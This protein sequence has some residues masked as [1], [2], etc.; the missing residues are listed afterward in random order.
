MIVERELRFTREAPLLAWRLFRVRRLADGYALCAPM[1]HSPSPPPWHPGLTV[2]RCLEHDHAAPAPGCR[3]GIYAAIEG[4]LDSLPGYLLDTAYDDDPWTYAEVACSGRVFLDARGVRCE[5]ALV[6]QIALVEESFASVDARVRAS[7][8]LA[9]RYG[10]CVGSS[11]AAPGWLADNSRGQGD[12]FETESV[13]LSMLLKNLDR[14]ERVTA[15][16]EA[17]DR[18]PVR[19][20]LTANDP[21][22]ARGSL[23]AFERSDPA[24]LGSVACPVLGS[25][26]RRYPL[27]WLGLH[28]SS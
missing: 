13:D 28:N 21:P 16:S 20:R 1:I 9:A 5:E 7:E 23:L 8:D 17:L 22:S 24:W 2:A 26:L 10:V 12:P 3:C 15:L 19:H 25:G 4:T 11:D 18:A 6:V 14:S 27:P